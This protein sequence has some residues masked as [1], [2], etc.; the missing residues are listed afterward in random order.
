MSGGPGKSPAVRIQAHQSLHHVDID[1]I[2]RHRDLLLTLTDRDVRVRYKQTAL[3]VVWVVLQPLLMSL[4]FAFV[5]GVVAGLAQ[6]ERPYLLFAFAGLMAWNTFAATI[7]RV[8][9]S[10]LS[11]ASMIS[12]IYFPRLVLPLSATASTLVDFGVSLAVMALML[13]YFRV[14]PGWGVL[15]LPVWLTALLTMGLGIGLVAA[16]LIVKYRDVGHIIPVALQLGMYISPVAWSARLVP[17]K[18][19]WVHQVNPLSGLLGAFR[20]SLVGETMPAAGALAYS[21]L[22]AVLCLAVG[23][24]VFQGQE[25]DFADVI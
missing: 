15:L 10:L 21:G 20:W 11:N 1:E 19:R 25:R 13:A 9:Y 24:A 22:F 7:N 17:D 16:A 23:V 14:W 6:D 2:I 4:I 8:G 3:G 5:F 18:Y 12:K